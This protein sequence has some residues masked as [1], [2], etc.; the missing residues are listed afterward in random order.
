MY[1]VRIFKSTR[2]GYYFG[3]FVREEN[4]NEILALMTDQCTRSA[5]ATVA[6]FEGLAG[7]PPVMLIEPMGYCEKDLV[8][9]EIKIPAKVVK[10]R[11][12]SPAVI[13]I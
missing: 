10:S 11:V 13:A 1:K 4:T 7:W 5:D 12:H 9:T 8:F 3:A 2:K 6:L